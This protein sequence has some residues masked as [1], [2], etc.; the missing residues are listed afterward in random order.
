MDLNNDAKEMASAAEENQQKE[1]EQR[2]MS[3]SSGLLESA[4][5]K[6][7]R[8]GGF[9]DLPLKG[10]PIKIEDGDVLTSIMKNA[11][12]Q[13]AWVEL[14]KE[15]AADIKRLLDRPE[16]NAVPEAE[17]EAINQKIMK[18]NRIVPNPQLQKGL[19]SGVHLHAAYEKWE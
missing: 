1:K 18:Y 9:D 8:E 14:R 2:P 12:Y 10:K 6:F 17:V 19:L 11:N 4:I 16:P 7:A 3:T 15:I 5:D 13:P